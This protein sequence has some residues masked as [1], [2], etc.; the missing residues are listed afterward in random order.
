MLMIRNVSARPLDRSSSR[1]KYVEAIPVC[2]WHPDDRGDRGPSIH[3]V[4][5]A[6]R[7]RERTVAIPWRRRRTYPI[8]SVEPD[9]RLEFLQ[10]ESRVGISWRQLRTRSRVH[11]AVHADL[12]ERH[13]LYRDRPAPAG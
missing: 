2:A 8:L 7:Y 12:C 13:A 4:G 10:I 1:R 6:G 3:G 5:A 9:Q 11:R